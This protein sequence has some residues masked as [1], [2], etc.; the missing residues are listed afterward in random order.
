MLLMEGTLVDDSDS[1]ANLICDGTVYMDHQ[2]NTWVSC[3]QCWP[4]CPAYDTEWH[5]RKHAV[6]VA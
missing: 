6:S 5:Y 3:I 4:F 1:R 2:H